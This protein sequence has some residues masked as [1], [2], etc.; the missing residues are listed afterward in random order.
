M[1]SLYRENRELWAKMEN[2]SLVGGINCLQDFV[3]EQ[4]PFRKLNFEWKRFG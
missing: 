1:E 4:K 3:Y 2:V